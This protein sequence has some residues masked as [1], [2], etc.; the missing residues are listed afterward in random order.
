MNP[1]NGHALANNPNSFRQAKILHPAIANN[2]GMKRVHS[3]E[4]DYGVRTNVKRV[5]QEDIFGTQEPFTAS[6]PPP[7]QLLYGQRSP[8]GTVYL[9]Q[10][11]SGGQV[12]ILPAT[13]ALMGS[14]PPQSKPL[15]VQTNSAVSSQPLVQPGALRKQVSLTVYF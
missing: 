2:T 4:E 9:H 8:G 12:R 15:Y 6:P 1:P 7:Q 13:V 3:P 14:Q 5:K 10:K 11:T